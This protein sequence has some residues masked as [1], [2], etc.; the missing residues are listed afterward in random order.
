VAVDLHA[1]RTISPA[2]VRSSCDWNV[3]DGWPVK[4]WPM[5]TMVRG[6]AV[7]RDGEIVGPP[8]WGRYQP[9]GSRADAGRGEP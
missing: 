2:L 9:R 4:G 6:Q 5:L 1:E 3:W 8:G 7:L